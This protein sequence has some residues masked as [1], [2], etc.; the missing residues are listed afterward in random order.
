M[1]QILTGDSWGEMARPL[2]FGTGYAAT[3]VSIY[4]VSF[5]ILTTYIL[6]N[7]VVAVLLE[8]IIDDGGAVVGAEPSH[9]NSIAMSSMH[10]VGVHRRRSQDSI[11]G[12]SPL[13]S[14]SDG[15]SRDGGAAGGGDVTLMHARLQR[16]ALEVER[17]A[18][19]SKARAERHDEQLA[20]VLALLQRRG[21]GVEEEEEEEEA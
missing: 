5:I 21:Q 3:A 7:V 1:F 6:L 20:R 10:G 19:D 12:G 2:L 14:R 17:L 16:L 9:R 8:K 15:E 4:F 13:A 11:S 18:A